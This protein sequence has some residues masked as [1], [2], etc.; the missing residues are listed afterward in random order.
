M[1]IAT[2]LMTALLLAAAAGNAMACSGAWKQTT[3]QN[4]DTPILPPSDARS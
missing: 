4:G 2:V 1:K 3:A